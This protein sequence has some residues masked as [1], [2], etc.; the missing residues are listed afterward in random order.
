M[1]IMSSDDRLKKKTLEI[2]DL[3]SSGNFKKNVFSLILLFPFLELFIS[4]WLFLKSTLRHTD[5]RFR[6]SESIV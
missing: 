3:I 1:T 2:I 5:K 4:F 6:G